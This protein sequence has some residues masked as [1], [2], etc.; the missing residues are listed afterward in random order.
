MQSNKGAT[1]GLFWIKFLNANVLYA[2]VNVVWCIIATRQKKL[3]RQKQLDIE[4]TN[5][6][7]VQPKLNSFFGFTKALANMTSSRLV[8]VDTADDAM[9]MTAIDLSNSTALTENIELR[10]ALQLNIGELDT[11]SNGLSVAQL[12]EQK[13]KRRK[14]DGNVAM[15]ALPLEN[16]PRFDYEPHRI[17]NNSTVIT[18]IAPIG[19]NTNS[20]WYRNRLADND[21]FTISTKSE[22]NIK[23]VVSF[24]DDKNSAI[25]AL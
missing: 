1:F 5:N 14:V 19:E 13:R 23:S 20:R 21:D 8:D 18:P 12:R 16:L 15:A 6:K 4:K 25:D 10:N 9:A 22:N 2:I 11:K 7:L 24:D 3:A 17:K